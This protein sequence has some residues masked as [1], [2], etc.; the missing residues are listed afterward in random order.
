MGDKERLHHILD[1]ISEIEN[2]TKGIDFADFESNSMM[3]FATIKQLEIIGEAC[4]RLSEELRERYPSVEW[5]KIIGLRN[6]LVHTYFS[7]SFRIV[8][9]I[10]R[11]DIP[12][13]KQEILKV[14]II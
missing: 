6:I 7:V 14:D 9:D 13:L 2:Y 1:A 8:W 5:R 12:T 4:N 10:V 3:K 11:Q